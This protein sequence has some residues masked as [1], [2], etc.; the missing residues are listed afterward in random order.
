MIV[1]TKIIGFVEHYPLYCCTTETVS[2]LLRR[3]SKTVAYQLFDSKHDFYHLEFFLWSLWVLMTKFGWRDFLK[4]VTK[5]SGAGDE[6]I[7]KKF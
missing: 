7:K 6:I 2:I 3:I 1:M 4:F 5:Y